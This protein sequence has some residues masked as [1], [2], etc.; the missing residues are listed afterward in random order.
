MKVL[1]SAFQAPV[2]PKRTT[3]ALG[4]AALLLLTLAITS[5]AG[6]SAAKPASST[7]AA[8]SD[9]KTFAVA[10]GIASSTPAA[11]ANAST[12]ATALPVSLTTLNGIFRPFRDDSGFVQSAPS[13][14]TVSTVGGSLTATGQ[15]VP[16][17]APLDSTNIF[18]APNAG[19]AGG[20]NQGCVTCH[21]PGQGFTIH[22]SFI[23]NTFASNPND[24]L[25]RFNDT[26]DNPQVRA[27][28]ADHYSII[29]NQGAVRI[30][31]TVNGGT[32]T[33]LAN[34]NYTI[35]A[36]DQYTVN[37]FGT[38][39]LTNDP[40][41]P[42]LATVSA[43][44]RP[45]VNTN[46]HLDSS[47]LWDGRAQIGNMQAQVVGAVKTLLLVTPTADQANQIAA[48][49]LGVYT[50]QV[51]DTAAGTDANGNCT[52]TVPGQQCGAGLT[53]AAGATGGT[54]NLVNLA[55]SPLIACNTP[56]TT[57]LLQTSA[58]AGGQGCIPNVP[59]YDLFDPWATLP[60]K[61]TNAGRL[62]AVRG[63][64]L[65]N[66]AVLH[67]P[68]DLIGQFKDAQGNDLT[69]IHCSTCHAK[70]NIGNN[71][72]ATFFVRNGTDSPRIIQ[73]LIASHPFD[74]DALTNLLSR[75]DAR[76]T[77]SV[78]GVTLPQYCI[79]PKGST[80]SCTDPAIQNAEDCT[81]GC[82]TT[83][84]AR[85]LVTG[86]IADV[87]KF[88]PPVMRGLA[89]RSPYFHAGVAQDIQT[90]IHFYNARFNITKPN[91]QPL[92]AHDINDLGSFM[93]AQ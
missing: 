48:F 68:T 28:T 70:H 84:P 80:A 58:T 14:V 71:P 87:G 88:K 27:P 63:Q 15:I 35:T 50:D 37:K 45:L 40:Q 11:S 74:A 77:P 46:V 5:C 83:D 81:N 44:R 53:D 67:V 2:V 21:Q 1:T 29:L 36:A 55:L 34:A 43:F 9:A 51:F 30:G 16:V 6:V 75:I 8:S 66:N 52:F 89:A 31:E 3:L 38:F 13:G 79:L 64:D 26:A 60:N 49:M 69:E 91:G 7:F 62:S 54:R 18:F 86:H 24:P 41:H 47:V 10:N 93:E 20:N 82:V 65:F 33:G 23:D 17:Q 72:D 59:G 42:G 85:A 12:S 56:E 90:A 25:F 92:T 39:P 19:I 32:P 78:P 22:V 61:G 57:N 4:V 73:N 76:L